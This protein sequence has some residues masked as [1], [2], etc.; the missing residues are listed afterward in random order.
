MNIKKLIAK[1]AH[2][3]LILFMLYVLGDTENKRKSLANEAA[4]AEKLR[5]KNAA[6]ARI[7]ED[8]FD[9]LSEE[10]QRNVVENA[11]FE[12][13]FAKILLKED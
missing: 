10:E 6:L 2:V 3:S 7:V 9:R 1:S 12:M 4:A 5:V 8:A 13:K 11:G